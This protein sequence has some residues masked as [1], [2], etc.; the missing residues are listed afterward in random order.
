MLGHATM[1]ERIAYGTPVEAAEEETIHVAPRPG[2]ALVGRIA[3]SVIFFV[4]GFAKLIDL[5]GTAEHMTAAGIPQAQAL[6]FI[7]GVAEILGAASIALGI[8][9]RVGALGLILLM[10]P[11]TLIFHGFWNYT[12]EAARAQLINF[13]KNLGLMGG[14]AML[15]AYGAGN[16]SADARVRRPLQP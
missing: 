5:P 9:T 4:S 13:L 10:I 8:L 16:Y 14:L 12:G 3:I 15:V 7:A 1:A 11:T 2:M 6:A